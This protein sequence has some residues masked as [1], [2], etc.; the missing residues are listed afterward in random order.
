M[1]A[2]TAKHAEIEIFVAL[3][4][5][6]RVALTARRT[7]VDRLGYAGVL[8]GLARED[9]FRLAVAGEDEEAYTYT[10]DMV[11]NTAVFANPTKETYTIA[12]LQRPLA[13][14]PRHV[15]LVYPREGLYSETLLRRLAFDLGYDRVI[16]AGRGVAWRIE[17]SADADA[18]YAEE[19]LVTR[20]R[21]RG[22]LL[23]PH[24]EQYEIV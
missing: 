3:R 22:L 23:N 16:A 5:A 14:A 6:D 4:V 18:A 21:T 10:R 8:V 12:H 7:L 17:L 15:A 24:A 20:E 11:E 9:Y 2:K 1:R 13:K 19:I